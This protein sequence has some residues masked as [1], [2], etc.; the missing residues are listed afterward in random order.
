[1]LA[2]GV[3]GR[4]TYLGFPNATPVAR[5]GGPP[6]ARALGGVVKD[7]GGRV[8]GA[9]EGGVCD[10]RHHPVHVHVHV[11]GGR[12]ELKVEKRRG[13][14]RGHVWAQTNKNWQSPK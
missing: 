10:S 6:D 7:A 1:M 9:T 12:R 4:G 14:G 8:E 3:C 11:Q 13:R 2:Q 5:E